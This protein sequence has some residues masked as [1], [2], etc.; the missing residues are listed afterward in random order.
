MG[1]ALI[2]PL[3][4]LVLLLVIW[5]A[6]SAKKTRDQ[7][8]DDATLPDHPAERREEELSRLRA[9]HAESDPTLT[10]HPARRP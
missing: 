5:F 2:F 7:A 3:A 6:F 8:R 10:Q 9:E 4:V 1:A